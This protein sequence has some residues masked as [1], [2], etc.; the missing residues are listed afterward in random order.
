MSQALRGRRAASLPAGPRL[1]P[2]PCDRL[3]SW[4]FFYR[5]PTARVSPRE[6]AER[7]ASVTRPWQGPWRGMASDECIGLGTLCVP[8]RSFTATRRA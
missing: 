1:D 5:A 6:L 7:L 4:H 3:H 2:V 8:L